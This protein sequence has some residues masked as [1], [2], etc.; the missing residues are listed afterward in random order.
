MPERFQLLATASRGTEDL[1]TSELEK[2]GANRVRQARG[3]V[4][5]HANWREALR[6]CLW[7]R[8]AMRVLL[9]LG[10]FQAKGSAG[11][12]EAAGQ[13]PYDLAPSSAV[14]PPAPR[15]V[16]R[17]LPCSSDRFLV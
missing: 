6:I 11:L 3:A 2:L 5:F 8:I 4:G 12:Y 14:V 10:K 9:P 17:S 15:W 13:V 16:K 7:S 1:L